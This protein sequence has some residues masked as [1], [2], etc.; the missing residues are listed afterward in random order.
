MNLIKSCDIHHTVYYK[1]CSEC[2]HEL[3][4]AEKDEKKANDKR[5]KQILKA[6][7]QPSQPKKTVSR[8][9]KDWKNTATTFRI[10]VPPA[11]QH[12]YP[13]ISL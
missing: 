10:R 3:A 1:V 11:S 13:L 5:E 7:L 12:P 2:L 4:K 9:P 6:K 8:N